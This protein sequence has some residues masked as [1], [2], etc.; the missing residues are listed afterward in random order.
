MII[1]ILEK[2]TIVLFFSPW[3]YANKTARLVSP[4][5]VHA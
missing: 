4:E 5:L 1:I 2:E 3:V